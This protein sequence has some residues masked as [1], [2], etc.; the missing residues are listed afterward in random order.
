MV[1]FELCSLFIAVCMNIVAVDETIPS[2]HASTEWPT[3]GRAQ[4]QAVIATELTT[5]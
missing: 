4:L 2:T 1:Y 3:I 5:V